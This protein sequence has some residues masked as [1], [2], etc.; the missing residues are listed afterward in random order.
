MKRRRKLAPEIVNH[1]ERK[2]KT[3]DVKRR[4]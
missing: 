2:R 1:V 4:A 3:R